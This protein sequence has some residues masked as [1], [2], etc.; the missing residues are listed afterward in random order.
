MRSRGPE[1]ICAVIGVSPRL[2]SPL[3]SVSRVMTTSDDQAFFRCEA[4][5]GAAR[6]GLLFRRGGAGL[7]DQLVGVTGNGVSSAWSERKVV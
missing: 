2:S 5:V 6:R 4:R 3:Y 1:A 7:M